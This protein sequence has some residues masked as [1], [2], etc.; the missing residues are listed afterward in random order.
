MAK[1]GKKT[2]IA[3]RRPQGK[4]PATRTLA[5]PVFAQPEATPDPAT[6]KIK[7]PSDSAAYKLID[8]LN[9]EHKIYPLPFPPPR[10]GNAEPQL[11]LAQV[12]GGNYAAVKRIQNT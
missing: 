1:R 4:T 10:G 5:A 8:R 12:F 6:F 11:N 2:A 3:R 7:H 9:A